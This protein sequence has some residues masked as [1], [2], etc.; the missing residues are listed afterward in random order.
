MVSEIFR[1][2]LICLFSQE[3]PYL[4]A[5]TVVIFKFK[6]EEKIIRISVVNLVEKKGQKGII[7]V[8]EGGRLKKIG[9]TGRL[10]GYEKVVR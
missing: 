10:N 1:R 6:S 8:K 3:I 5:V 9:I 4:L 7:I 2:K